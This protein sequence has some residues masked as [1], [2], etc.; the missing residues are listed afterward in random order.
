MTNNSNNQPFSLASNYYRKVINFLK[1]YDKFAI[2]VFTQNNFELIDFKI[3]ID[4]IIN[5]LP[6]KI[7]EVIIIHYVKDTPMFEVMQA[8]EINKKDFI[9]YKREGIR[10]IAEELVARNEH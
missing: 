1:N 8:L 7:K 9:F 4:N 5:S 2:R 6:S 10:I 3:D